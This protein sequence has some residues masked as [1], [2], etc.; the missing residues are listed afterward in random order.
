MDSISAA[1]SGAAA[2]H[3]V[4][5]EESMQALFTSSQ[6]QIAAHFTSFGSVLNKI[7]ADQEELKKQ[8]QDL[9][10]AK[11]T[12]VEQDPFASSPF[13]RS[14]RA[15]GGASSSASRGTQSRRRPRQQVHSITD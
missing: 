5:Q 14:G 3:K 10:S 9:T 8:V 12:H 2:S 1:E 15:T 11:A 4:D 13:T 7:V 6:A